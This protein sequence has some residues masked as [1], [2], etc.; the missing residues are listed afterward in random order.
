MAPRNMTAGALAQAMDLS[1]SEHVERIIG[2]LKAMTADTALR[3]ERVLGVNA[4][5]SMNLQTQ[6]DLSKAPIE[7]RTALRAAIC[8]SPSRMQP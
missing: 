7:G 6:H 4:Q 5:F 8:L 3:L 2:E 1:G